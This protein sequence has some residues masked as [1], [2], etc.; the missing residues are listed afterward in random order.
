MKRQRKKED[1]FGLGEVDFCGLAARGTRL[2]TRP[3]ASVKVHK[4]K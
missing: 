4:N 3:V 1:W 2:T